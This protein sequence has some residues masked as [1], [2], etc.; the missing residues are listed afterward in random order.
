MALRIRN[1][2]DRDTITLAEFHRLRKMPAKSG[3]ERQKAYRQRKIESGLRL[4]KGRFTD[5]P[6]R[7][8]RKGE[9]PPHGTNRRYNSAQFDCRC[10]R[11]LDARRD[12]CR[13]LREARR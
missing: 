5:E 11:C 1:P 10:Q 6:L 2:D 8:A 3:A 9:A 4:V 13:E 7:N 12:Y